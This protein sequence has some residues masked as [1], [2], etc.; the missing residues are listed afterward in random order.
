MCLPL[1]RAAQKKS[2]ARSGSTAV[3]FKLY[4]TEVLVSGEKELALVVPRAPGPRGVQ[5]KI[6]VLGSWLSAGLPGTR[7]HS[8]ILILAVPGKGPTTTEGA[9]FVRIDIRFA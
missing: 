9:R 7:G 6:V 1:C 8:R 4:Y 3:P 2:A 5:L